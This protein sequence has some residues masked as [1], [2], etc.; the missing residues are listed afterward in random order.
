MTNSLRN[1]HDSKVVIFFCT[2]IM[3]SCYRYGE[4]ITFE[5]ENCAIDHNA[6]RLNNDDV[7]VAN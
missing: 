1:L 2:V 6:M 3:F 5:G 4:Y 7:L